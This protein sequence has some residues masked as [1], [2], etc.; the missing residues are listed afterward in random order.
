MLESLQ[1]I[2]GDRVSSSL[3]ERCCYSSDASQVSGRPD[4]VVRPANTGE[5][6]R[7]LLLCNE[8]DVPVVA[9][10]READLPA[11]RLQSQGAW[12]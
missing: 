12:F 7:I 10:E 9:R 2:A 1:E 11:G 4:F 5:V 8:R 3:S 6:S